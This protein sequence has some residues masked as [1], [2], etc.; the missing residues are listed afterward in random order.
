MADEGVTTIDGHAIE[1]RLTGEPPNNHD[2]HHGYALVN[3]LPPSAFEAEHIP[4]SIN[5]PRGREAELEARFDKDKEIILYCASE[6]CDASPAVA[7]D[8]VRRGFTA[9]RDYEAG[10]RDWKE[11]GRAIEGAPR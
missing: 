11:R 2:R 10:L 3:V 1:Q 9:V 5:I 7:R 4:N 8:L 6:E